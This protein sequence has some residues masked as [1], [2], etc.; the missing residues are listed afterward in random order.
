VATNR[1]H[2]R[3]DR[4]AERTFRHGSGGSRTGGKRAAAQ[5]AYFGKSVAVAE[6]GSGT[7]RGE[8]NR[9]MMMTTGRLQRD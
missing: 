3:H 5:L 8:T 6:K 1:G 9:A 4:G 2:T 7:R